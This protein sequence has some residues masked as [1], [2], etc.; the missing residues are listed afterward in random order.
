MRKGVA[1]AVN[2]STSDACF[3]KYLPFFLLLG[4]LALA[5]FFLSQRFPGVL[6]DG[7]S[8]ARILYL[9]MLLVVVAPG[10]FYA[11]RGAPAKAIKA[12]FLWIGIFVAVFAV[13]MHR[14]DFMAALV[15]SAPYTHSSGEVEIRRAE[16]GHYYTDALVNGERV[17]FM[18]DTGASRVA[19]S[20]ED[21][22]RIGVDMDGLSYTIPV[23]TANGIAMNAATLLD[24]VMVGDVRIGNVKA[25]V[26]RKGQMQGS[27]LGMS[28]LER[29]GGYR[30]EGDTLHMWAGKE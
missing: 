12:I 5:V 28:F 15:P 18:I 27:L 24:Y 19:L 26:A 6:D 29:L 21:A 23:G 9:A 1:G 25:S 20:Y 14:E 10:A 30:I 7:F 17:R 2:P 4:A 11:Y 22:R 13:V 8:F 16:D 3:M